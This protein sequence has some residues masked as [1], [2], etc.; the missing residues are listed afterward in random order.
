MI[1]RATPY[2]TGAVT[3]VF[4]RVSITVPIVVG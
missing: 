4:N 1:G 2:G 3:V